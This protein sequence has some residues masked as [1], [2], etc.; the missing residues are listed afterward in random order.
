MFYTFRCK[1]SLL[2]AFFLQN[3]Y[4]QFNIADIHFAE[5]YEEVT[6][7][8]NSI[9]S[10]QSHI[11]LTAD[12]LKFLDQKNIGLDQKTALIQLLGS[13]SADNLNIYK[14]HL[15]TK[16]LLKPTVL[17]SVL[18][19]PLYPGEAFCESAQKISAQDLCCLGYLQLLQ[20]MDR[21]MLA[22]KSAY[23]AALLLPESETASVI[24]GLVLAVSQQEYDWCNACR[25]MISLK[26][27][28]QFKQDKFNQA[29]SNLIYTPFEI[30][31]VKCHTSTLTEGPDIVLITQQSESPLYNSIVF[32]DD[33]TNGSRIH[34]IIM[35][36][37]SVEFPESV[38]RFSFHDE[39]EGQ[40]PFNYL[41]KLP[42]VAAGETIE[43]DIIIPDYKIFNP[44]A[45]F[46]IHIDPNN[47]IPET[48]EEN[49]SERFHE[50]G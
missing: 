31:A 29:A 44:N 45:D 1:L 40:E 3:M 41:S 36:K 19:D 34:L 8:G 46:D 25:H 33:E 17:D 23:R 7:I 49:N 20:N 16:Y 30:D 15:T 28:Q 38:I 12:H 39:L 10:N 26:Q 27:H 6:I 35:N 24:N 9:K 4:A 18:T 22:Y 47:L 42:T 5:A 14:K 37:G 11:K 32:D 50:Q 21:P 2:F 13:S 48:N 43:A